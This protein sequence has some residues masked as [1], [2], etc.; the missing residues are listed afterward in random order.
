[1]P[2]VVWIGLLLLCGALLLE[3]VAPQEI[4]EGF[5]QLVPVLSNKT[6]FFTKYVPKRGDVG[7]NKEQSGYIMDAR[8]FHDYVDVQ[9]FGL[10]QDYCRVVVPD[11]EDKEAA[12]KKAFFACALA[13]TADTPSLLFATNTVQEGLKLSR[14]DYM[15]DIMKDGRAAYCRILKGNDGTYQPLCRRALD[16]GFSQRDEVDPDPPEDIIKLLSFYD[17]CKGWLRLR[18]DML[19]YVGNLRVMRAGN[20]GILEKPR[21]DATEGLRFDG[22]TQYLRIADSPDLTLGSIVNLRTIRAFSIWVY[23]DKFTNNAHFFDFGDGPGKNNVFLGILGKGDPQLGGGGE[24]RPLL[25]G[26]ETTIPDG[27]SGAQIVEEVSPK[28]LMKT[29][30]ANVDEYVDID[31]E[32][33]ARILPPSTVRMPKAK[34]LSN[35]A[36][37]QYEVWDQRQRK[38]SVKINGAI[39]EKKWTHIAVTAITG[40]ATRPDIA[41]FVNGEQ[42]F[43]QPSGFLPQPNMT[44]KNYIGKSNWADDSSTY[45]LRDELF[46][47]KMFDF[48]MYTSQMSQAKI[49][50][51][52]AWGKKLLGLTV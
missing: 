29:T 27:P 15:R 7:P 16:T 20:I 46:A 14:D 8:Y 4:T 32:V 42:I 17:G 34:G 51:T 33:N 25:C 39:E 41:I 3:L 24:L 21:P 2:G 22:F 43:V 49:K 1:M 18:D 48:R 38:M 47:G 35:K 11:E 9:R 45:E 31:Q 36:T 28:E 30:R 40:D 5:Q 10:D 50:N 13:G 19:D 6:S 52:Y 37:L 23:F 26:A 44:S 12:Q